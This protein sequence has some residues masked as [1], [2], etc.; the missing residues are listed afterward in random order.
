MFNKKYWTICVVAAILLTSCAK[1][2]VVEKQINNTKIEKNDDLVIL[3][4]TSEEVH[5]L[6]MK[7]NKGELDKIILL[8]KSKLEELKEMYDPKLIEKMKIYDIGNKEY[9]L[10][11]PIKINT[12]SNTTSELIAKVKLENDDA[13]AKFYEGD[14]I[15]NFDK[16]ELKINNDKLVVWSQ[17]SN[18]SKERDAIFD[19]EKNNID[20]VKVVESDPTLEYYEKLIKLLRSGDIETAMTMDLN[21]AYKHNYQDL[22]FKTATMSVRI[23]HDY[24]FLLYKDDSLS[25][26]DKLKKS[27]KAINWG[28]NKYLEAQINKSLPINDVNDFD[29]LFESLGYRDK[30]KLKKA[31]F[32]SVLNDYA[33][34]KYEEKNYSE[35]EKIMKKVL[36]YSPNRIVAQINM[37]DILWVMDRKDEA[38]N[39]YE[40]YVELLGLDNSVIPDR[41]FERLGYYSKIESVKD[42]E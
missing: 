33:Y 12:E 11:T 31:E 35:A 16:L 24:A 18:S 20:L 14:F 8:V 4:N 19:L 26:S 39:Y 5:L 2:V 13:I 41:V 17:Y 42:H 6:S 3:E 21:P 7:L 25:E 22:Y 1:N 29:L 37:G 15:A 9:I 38:R 27:K 10:L 40:K 30:Y 32:A 28:L 34:F 23:A 36:E